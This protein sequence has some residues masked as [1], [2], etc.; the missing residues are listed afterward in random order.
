MQNILFFSDIVANLSNPL[1]IT[2]LIIAVIAMVL[3]FASKKIAVSVIDKKFPGMSKESEKY[4][5]KLLNTTLI[6]KSIAAGLAVAA[7]ILSLL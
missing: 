3:L 6:F 1:V 7:C 4:K 5:N 2:G